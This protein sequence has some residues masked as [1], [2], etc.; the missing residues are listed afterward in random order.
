MIPAKKN[1]MNARVNGG[2]FTNANLKIG[3]AA[4]QI[5]LAIIK[6]TTGFM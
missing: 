1:R 5:I 3:E 2:I 4:P 6:A